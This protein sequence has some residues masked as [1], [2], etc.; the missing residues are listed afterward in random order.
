MKIHSGGWC[1]T[2]CLML[3]ANGETPERMTEKES[4]A[5]LA[6]IDRRTEGLDVALGGEHE[7]NCPNVIDGQWMGTTDCGCER[8]EFSWSQCDTCGSRLGGSRE[9]VT[10]FE[11]EAVR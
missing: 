11:K 4:A 5:W 7:E 6:E 3:F 2:D 8:Q 10:F 9:A 1:C